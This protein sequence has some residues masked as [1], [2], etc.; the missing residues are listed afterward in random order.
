MAVAVNALAGVGGGYCAV[1]GT[2]VRALVPLPIAGLLSEEPLEALADAVNAVERVLL[3]DLGCSITSHPLYAL[4]FLCL[5]NI[6]E[7]GM[8]DQGIVATAALSIVPTV[9]ESASG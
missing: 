7:V 5:P 3:D 9:V 1:V 4:N 6:P 2:E 8:T